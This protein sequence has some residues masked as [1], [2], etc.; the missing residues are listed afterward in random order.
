MRREEEKE[1]AGRK[2]AKSD[3]IGNWESGEGLGRAIWNEIAQL[4]QAEGVVIISDDG[5]F[6]CRSDVRIEKSR[7]C[8]IL[9]LTS[10]VNATNI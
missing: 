8:G 5:Y 2:R 7:H 1:E 4:G 3:M 9:F 10:F 6:F